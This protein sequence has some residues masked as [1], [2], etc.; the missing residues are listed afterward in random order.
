[1]IKKII[2]IVCISVLFLGSTGCGKN[3]KRI[4][5]GVVL[6][7]GEATRWKNEIKYMKERAKE[8]KV[9]IETRLHKTSSEESFMDECKAVI[10]NGIDVLLMTPES[11]SSVSDC[12]KI[13]NY[14]K[15]KGVQ[16]VSYVRYPLEVK[17]DLHIGHDN[18][19]IG[20][21]LGQYLTEISDH[22]DY[23]ILSGD[24]DDS[25]AKE[26]YQGAMRYIEPIKDN[27][28][29]L[30]NEK[31]PQWSTQEAKKMVKKAIEDNHHKVDAILAPNDKI[32]GAC[33]EVLQELNITTNVSVT[34]MDAELEAIQ[35]IAKGTQ[36]MSVYMDFRELAYLAIDQAIELANGNSPKANAKLENG[37]KDGID[38]KL[39]AGKVITKQNINT[40][41]IERGIYTKE[42]IYN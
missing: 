41:I 25:N 26:I 31:V 28:H 36:A 15:R 14:A 27:I 21:I 6:G 30:L 35:R 8:K 2:C 10:D 11:N 39:I 17:V 1:M 19:K 5:I 32:A 18:N 42:Q 40:A 13:I 9:A 33:I 22:G 4:S 23:I 37:V 34:G 12:T 3:D 24:K 16:V 7:V 29:I 20:Q 38:A